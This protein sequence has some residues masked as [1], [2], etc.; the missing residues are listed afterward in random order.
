[1][2]GWRIVFLSDIRLCILNMQDDKTRRE[3]KSLLALL[4][5]IRTK[6]SVAPESVQCRGD[7]SHPG[8]QQDCS[9]C[10]QHRTVQDSTSA[11]CTGAATPPRTSPV[12]FLCSTSVWKNLGVATC[13][14][15]LTLSVTLVATLNPD[16]RGGKAY[17]RHSTDARSGS[18]CSE[19]HTEWTREHSKFGHTTGSIPGWAPDLSALLPCRVGDLGFWAP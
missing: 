4:G 15:L 1:M 7:V 14:K 8:M 11:H 16:E 3:E 9:S 6:H 2:G 12:S 19:N 5:K 17:A 18:V 13:I 10:A